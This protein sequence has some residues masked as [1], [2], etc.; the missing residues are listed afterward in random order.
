MVKVKRRTTMAA[1]PTAERH[2]YNVIRMAVPPT[3]GARTGT[4]AVPRTLLFVLSGLL[5]ATLL[6]V[7]FLLGREAGREETAAPDQ[8]ADASPAPIA[9]EQARRAAPPPRPEPSP[10]PQRDDAEQA[11]PSRSTSTTPPPPA[12]VPVT[13]A[14]P[15]IDLR[16]RAAVARYF[17]EVDAIAGNNVGTGDPE[18][19]A[20]AL[21]SQATGGD[22]SQFDELGDSQ[23][24]ALRRLRG[25]R[26]PSVCRD[27]HQQ[28]VTLLDAGA[29]LLDEVRQG[30]QSG[31]LGALS[32]LA[33]TSQ[34]LQADAE[35]ASR[36]ADDLRQRYGL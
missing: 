32:T 9:P 27:Y 34:R 22:W 23:R 2:Q 15:A 36:L 4:V 5:L 21:V 24:A 20:M 28:M 33:R 11:R 25:L 3:S 16:E 31:S 14:E 19:M 13:P 1:T 12:P 17:E 8:L 7:A 29:S 35:T 26:V 18:T 6:A 10:R 30:V